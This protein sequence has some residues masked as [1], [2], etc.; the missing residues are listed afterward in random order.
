VVLAQETERR[1]LAWDIHDGIA[2]RLVSL[3]YHLDAA[4]QTIRDD[5]AYA[6]EQVVLARRL[7]D[8]TME[9]ARAAI[10]GLRP[11]VLDDLGLAGGLASLV[12]SVPGLQIAAELSERLTEPIEIAIYRIAQEALQNVVK[13]AAATS[14]LVIFSVRGSMARLE[15]RDDGA[16]FNPREQQRTSESGYGLTSMA[17]RAELVGGTLSIRSRTGSGTSIIVNVPAPLNDDQGILAP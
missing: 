3:S 8:L 1:R 15:V 14:A 6:A 16:G 13:H 11:P 9:E 5:P 4:D 7:A 12:K 10:S 17:Q 2:Q